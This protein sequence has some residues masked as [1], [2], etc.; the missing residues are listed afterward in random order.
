MRPCLSRNSFAPIFF[1]SSVLGI[2]QT[3]SVFVSVPGQGLS[4]ETSLSRHIQKSPHDTAHARQQGACHGHQHMLKAFKPGVDLG[5]A[6]GAYGLVRI[7]PGLCLGHV[8]SPAGSGVLP[9]ASH[10]R[11]CW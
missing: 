8:A 10:A 11:Y 3:K 9:S 7:E 2:R 4:A 6:L 5:V 1:S